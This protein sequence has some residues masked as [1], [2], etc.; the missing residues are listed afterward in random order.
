MSTAVSN[1]KNERQ[2]GS[3]GGIVSLISLLLYLSLGIILT[4]APVVPDVVISYTS[5][6]ASAAIREH[7]YVKYVGREL[8]ALLEYRESSSIQEKS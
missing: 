6:N 4:C 3:Q 5:Q 8:K 2:N 7:V 1:A